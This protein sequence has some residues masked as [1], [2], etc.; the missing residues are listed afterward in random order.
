MST[1]KSHKETGALFFAYQSKGIIF[2]SKDE[3]MYGIGQYN[4]AM[5]RFEEMISKFGIPA[6]IISA[7][8]RKSVQSSI[9]LR[10]K[11]S[12]VFAVDV[13]F[14]IDILLADYYP[15]KNVLK[16]QSD[17]T[18]SM[19]SE[20][21]SHDIDDYEKT[22]KIA[23]QRYSQ[24]MNTIIDEVTNDPSVKMD[25]SQN[26]ELNKYS[27]RVVVMSSMP[28]LHHMIKFQDPKLYASTMLPEKGAFIIDWVTN[29]SLSKSKNHR[30]S[31]SK[32]EGSSKQKSSKKSTPTKAPFTDELDYES[33]LDHDPI[34][35]AK[36]KTAL[37]ENPS[38][39]SKSQ[40]QSSSDQTESDDH[41][42]SVDQLSSEYSSSEYSTD[43]SISEDVKTESKSS[44]DKLKI[45]Y[46][47]QRAIEK[48]MMSELKTPIDL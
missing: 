11:I 36:R 9:W 47:R 43:S 22:I 15:S 33:R 2:D 16:N 34:R 17:F 27:S 45:K 26:K 14:A 13:P 28:V 37:K 10:A 30:S 32:K 20:K 3:C 5:A 8:N 18:R 29:F 46:R 38:K 12:Q 31:V 48:S 41:S 24:S 42:D 1:K 6:M 4:Y 7:P 35:Q 23:I 21:I 39:K 40:I 44:K 19:L 25:G